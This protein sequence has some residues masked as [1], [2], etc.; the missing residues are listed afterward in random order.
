MAA[1]EAMR[2]PHVVPKEFVGLARTLMRQI[3]PAVDRDREAAIGALI[4][5]LRPRARFIPMPTHRL[6]AAI[7][8]E[9]LDLADRGRLHLQAT[10]DKRRGLEID[11]VQV[12]PAKLDFGDA[13]LQHV[14]ALVS[15][16][17]S[18]LPPAFSERK[19]CVAIVGL[20]AMARRFERGDRTAATVKADLLEL[21]CAALVV[22]DVRGPLEIAVGAGKWC[23]TRF[24]GRETPLIRTW[25]PA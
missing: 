15:Y 7:A 10:F 12:L 21:A 14:I 17:L 11:E 8:A 3:G 18:A 9:Y 2:R 13:D 4:A 25:L 22:S 16:R 5:P 20:H 23:G 6:L 24:E 19:R 1:V